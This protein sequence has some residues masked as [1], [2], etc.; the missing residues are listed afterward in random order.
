MPAHVIA[1]T[2]EISQ[3][4]MTRLIQKYNI[5]LPSKSYWIG[6]DY[7]G[8]ENEISFI[9][10]SEFFKKNPNELLNF[11]YQTF[12]FNAQ[13]GIRSWVYKLKKKKKFKF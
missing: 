12:P 1:R 11:Y 2:F 5:K 8:K 3:S 10:F 6:R 13:S 4:T 7:I 9:E